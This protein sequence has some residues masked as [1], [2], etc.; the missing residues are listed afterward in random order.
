[1]EQPETDLDELA[2]ILKDSVR[3]DPADLEK[4]LEILDKRNENLDSDVVVK[5][6]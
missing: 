6:R 2:R 5:Q 3:M 1:M 4:N